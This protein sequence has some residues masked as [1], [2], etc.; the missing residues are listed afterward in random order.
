[1]VKNRNVTEICIGIPFLLVIYENGMCSVYEEE[2]GKFISFLN[3]P[4][5]T[6]KTVYNNEMNHSLLVV[7]NEREFIGTT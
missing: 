5:Q 3:K 1:M 6:I 4:D 2:S 7:A